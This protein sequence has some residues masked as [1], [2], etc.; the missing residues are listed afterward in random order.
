ML[1]INRMM[2]CSRTYLSD[3]VTGPA[4]RPPGSFSAPSISKNADDLV[5]DSLLEILIQ[6]DTPCLLQSEDPDNVE[7]PVCSDHFLCFD[8]VLSKLQVRYGVYMAIDVQ[9]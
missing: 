8:M 7:D 1:Q 4:S 6:R 3:T 9:I 5:I 2:K